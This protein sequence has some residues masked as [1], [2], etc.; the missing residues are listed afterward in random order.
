MMILAK[1]RVQMTLD[2]SCSCCQLQIMFG[3]A[4]D[5]S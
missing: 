3:M 2:S 5:D 1:A 4:A